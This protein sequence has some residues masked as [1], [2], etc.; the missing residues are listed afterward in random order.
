[1]AEESL[2][3]PPGRL[4]GQPVSLLNGPPGRLTGPLARLLTGPLASLLTGP[5]A[6]PPVGMDIGLVAT[7][8]VQELRRQLK[9][10]I[11]KRK[12][13]MYVKYYIYVC[14]PLLLFICL[15]ACILEFVL[16]LFRTASSRHVSKHHQFYTESEVTSQSGKK[17][18]KVLKSVH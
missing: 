10:F 8:R 7:T 9:K 17:K 3:G 1:M 15:T 4:A 18:S 12:C 6:S 14:V 5:L 2:T 16:T 11:G 13:I